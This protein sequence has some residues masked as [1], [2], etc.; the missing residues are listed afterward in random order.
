M[1]IIATLKGAVKKYVG[2]WKYKNFIRNI[3]TIEIYRNGSFGDGA[4][5]QK[6]SHRSTGMTENKTEIILQVSLTDD[7]DIKSLK[8]I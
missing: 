1:K 4:W 7:G 6:M 2:Q 5:Q 8:Y 3:F